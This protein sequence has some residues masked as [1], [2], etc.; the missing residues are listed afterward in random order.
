MKITYQQ[1]KTTIEFNDWYTFY[2]LSRRGHFS[3]QKRLFFSSFFTFLISIKIVHFE[4]IIPLKLSFHSSNQV[5]IDK[6]STTN[7]IPDSF[8]AVG[9]EED[10][11]ALFVVEPNMRDLVVD[12]NDDGSKRNHWVPIYK[13][14]KSNTVD[15]VIGY[16][17][18]T[19]PNNYKDWQLLS[20]VALHQPFKHPTATEQNAAWGLIADTLMLEKDGNVPLFSVPLKARAVRGRFLQFMMKAKKG[21]RY[22]SLSKWYG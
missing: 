19:E 16:S 18:L 7:Q 21:Q 17:C 5:L 11:A 9:L 3:Y 15:T 6:M 2:A 13:K 1:P 10:P 8:E 4:K 14:T 22:S 20:L 12:K